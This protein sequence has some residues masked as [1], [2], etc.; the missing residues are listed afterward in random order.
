MRKIEIIEDETFCES[1]KTSQANQPIFCTPDSD[2]KK[3]ETLKTT[4]YE[5]GAYEIA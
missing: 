5:Q 4:L 2:E 3:L 1:P